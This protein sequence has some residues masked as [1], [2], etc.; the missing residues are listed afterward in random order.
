[1]ENIAGSLHPELRKLGRQDMEKYFN[2]D[3]IR[4][5]HLDGWIADCMFHCGLTSGG[6]FHRLDFHVQE[7]YFKGLEEI[8]FGEHPP[9]LI[10]FYQ[11]K[12]D[13]SKKYKSLLHELHAR[14]EDFENSITDF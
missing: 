13:E 3:D 6:G 8:I 14:A 1:M 12:L 10:E 11:K 4:R 5:D 7:S 9:E 2:P